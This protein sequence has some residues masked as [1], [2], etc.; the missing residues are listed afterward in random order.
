MQRAAWS[1]ACSALSGDHELLVMAAGGIRAAS[2]AGRY[3]RSR[4]SISRKP[5]TLAHVSVF[6]RGRDIGLGRL[7]ISISARRYSTGMTLT[8]SA[9]T[10]GPVLQNCPGAGAAGVVQVVGDELVQAL[11]VMADMSPETSMR[12]F[13]SRS[14]P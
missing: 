14:P 8:N 11:V 6:S 1:R 5:V 3:F 2:E 4:R 12:P 10:P 13:Y 9:G 7:R